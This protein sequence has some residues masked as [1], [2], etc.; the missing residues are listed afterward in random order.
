MAIKFAV[1]LIKP[2]NVMYGANAICIGARETIQEA[3][4][5]RDFVIREDRLNPNNVSVVQYQA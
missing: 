5:Y 3:E 1:V 4:Q 2:E